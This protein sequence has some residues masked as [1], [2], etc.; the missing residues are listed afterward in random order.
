MQHGVR[1]VE[2]YRRTLLIDG[3]TSDNDSVAPVYK[4]EEI[5]TLLRTS[6]LDIVREV[7]DRILKRLDNKSPIVKQ[8]ALRLIKFAAQGKAGSDFRREIQR[9]APAIRN[10]LHHRGTPDALKGDALNKAVRETAQEALSAIF[11]STE[12]KP[13]AE[14]EASKRSMEGFGNTNYDSSSVKPKSSMLD[15]II[16]F[17]SRSLSSS[18]GSGNYG[19]YRGPD[20]RSSS[21]I[22]KES[23]YSSL[24]VQAQ[25][26]S[27]GGEGRSSVS[28]SR[29][30]RLVDA[31]TT[32]GGVRLQPSREAVQNFLT[33]AAELDVDRLFHA[34]ESKL[35][36]HAWQVRLK[37][38]CVV[39]AIVRQGDG[40]MAKMFADDCGAIVENA[41]SPQASLQEKSKKVLELLG[42]GDSPSGSV[43]VVSTPPPQPV[44]LPDLM[45]G[46]DAPEETDAAVAADSTSK[47]SGGNGDNDLLAGLSLNASSTS[48]AAAD[49]LF[50]GLNASS[51]SSAATDDLFSGLNASSTSSAADDLFSGLHV[52]S[53]SE[54]ARNAQ[55]PADSLVDLFG[56]L[57]TETSS[58]PTVAPV[59]P[60]KSLSSSAQPNVATVDPLKSLLSSSAA[61]SIPFSMTGGNMGSQG[62]GLEPSGYAGLSLLQIQQQLAANQASMQA[63][64][65]GMNLNAGPMG[66]NLNAGTMGMNLT[67]GTPQGNGVFGTPQGNGMYGQS[68]N[69]GFDFSSGAGSRYTTTETKKEETKAFDWLKLS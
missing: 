62:F 35:Q 4:L 3:V 9:Q 57:S 18:G 66:M 12:T 65:M 28:A 34:L 40:R 33:A 21:V 7:V 48:S 13:P 51:T 5:C 56:G 27:S 61:A 20:L 54:P 32:P 16:G 37:A 52:D 50:S 15:D 68:F 53:V 59:D 58:K 19:S 14:S 49:D 23:K 67:A 26:R 45:G 22:E 42:L 41:Q 31:I 44:L 8:K 11:A 25:S 24:E 17:R 60:F 30:D 38:T 43:P 36:T 10:L 63:L 6:S 29:E 47:G 2:S 69:D 46:W 1:A 39:E 55:P 64:R